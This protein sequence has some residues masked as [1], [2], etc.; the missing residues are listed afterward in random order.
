M[1]NKQLW[2]AMTNQKSAL[3][4]F[5]HA[6]AKLRNSLTRLGAVSALLL[7]LTFIGCPGNSP[8]D[9]PPYIPSAV[10]T[11]VSAVD[12]TNLINAPIKN[13][14]P[15]TTITTEAQYTGTITWQTEGSPALSNDA[16][17]LPNT[18]Y[19]ANVTLS[20]KPGYTFS[21][22]AAGAIIYSGIG[23]ITPNLVNSGNV[24][25]SFQATTAVGVDIPVNDLNLTSLIKAPVAG[26]TPSTTVNT[27]DDPQYT[28]SSVQWQ[29]ADGTAFSDPFAVSTV[30][31]AVL[32]LDAEDDFTFTGVTAFTYT[33]STKVTST[34]NS[35]ATIAVTITFPAIAPTLTKSLTITGIPTAA[36]GL[37]LHCLVFLTT[38]TDL[39]TAVASAGG[40]PIL[41][42]TTSIAGDLKTITSSGAN[43]GLSNDNWVGSGPYYV[44]LIIA[45]TPITSP[46]QSDII[47]MFLTRNPVNF[48]TD[49]TSLSI[50]DF[51]LTGS[52][53]GDGKTLTINGIPDKIQGK[54]YLAFLI[55]FEQLLNSN[56][57]PTAVAIGGIPAGTTSITG[58]LLSITVSGESYSVSSSWNGSGLYNVGI[59][60]E[61][62]DGSGKMYITTLPVNF[63]KNATVSFKS[64]QSISINLTAVS[65]PNPP[66]TATT[67]ASPLK[68]LD[69]QAAPVPYLSP[70]LRAALLPG[71]H[72]LS[73]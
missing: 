8:S 51:E 11:M 13:K 23:I 67:R 50:L 48:D 49:P 41:T 57:I 71:E 1:Y 18:V 60:V 33:G 32:T 54:Y 3:K 27:P 68:A 14:V 16:K 55:T 53:P 5:A 34:E 19:T 29:L 40:G 36:Q 2:T 17:F 30:Y 28:V 61:D 26:V 6:E 37:G 42:G 44:S 72:F 35:G 25:I 10:D 63:N 73:Q 38:T 9:P 56:F 15:V 62:T 47:A 46:T 69:G 58:N 12:L 65:Q 22:F 39:T 4:L 7:A 21:G 31:K 45:T 24:T 52:T 64:F 20:A 66:K 59:I 70:I 43:L